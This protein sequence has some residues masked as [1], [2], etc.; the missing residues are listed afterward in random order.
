MKDLAYLAEYL[1]G[2]TEARKDWEQYPVSR[3]T[4]PVSWAGGA[5]K[6]QRS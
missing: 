2:Q 1:Q 6:M 3:R 5:K 4:W